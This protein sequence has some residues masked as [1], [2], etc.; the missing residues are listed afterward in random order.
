MRSPNIGV[1]IPEK[2]LGKRI[3][4]VKLELKGYARQ[5]SPGQVELPTAAYERMFELL[6]ELEKK[7][8]VLESMVST[9]VNS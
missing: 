4:L 2:N 8:E 1:H 9:G 5:G 7:I 6:L 3:N